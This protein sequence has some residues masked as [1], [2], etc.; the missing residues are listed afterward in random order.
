MNKRKC[1][2]RNE[3]ISNYICV[4]KLIEEI[5]SFVSFNGNF[6]IIGIDGPTAS[7]K[8]TLADS[9]CQE[10][11]KR[12][13]DYF[14]YRLDWTLIERSTRLS[15]LES[16]LSENKKFLHESDLHMDLG[17]AKEF[18]DIIENERH[19][20]SFS[21]LKVQCNNLYN[22]DDEGKCSGSVS[23]TLKKNMVI[24]VEG[25]YTHHRLLR[26][27]FDLNILLI[28]S[29]KELLRRKILRV[30]KYRS[31]EN[32]KKYFNLIDIPS[33]EHYYFQNRS[34]FQ[35]IILNENFES[36]EP[37]SIQEL[38]TLFFDKSDFSYNINEL[39]LVRDNLPEKYA[40][41]R[42]SEFLFGVAG[43]MHNLL[44]Q[45][46]GMHPSSRPKGISEQVEEFML[47][48]DIE[49]RFSIFSLTGSNDFFYEFGLVFHETM[50]IITGRLKTIML[51]VVSRFSKYAFKNE[52]DANGFYS[53]HGFTRISTEE[54]QQITSHIIAPN[55]FLVP[56][57][58]EAGNTPERIFY[59]TRDQ[60][61]DNAGII[62]EKPSLVV[63]KPQ[64]AKQTE[65]YSQFLSLI[66]YDVVFVFNYIFANNL[67]GKVLSEKFREFI[68]HFPEPIIGAGK[69]VNFTYESQLPDDWFYLTKERNIKALNELY[70]N[71]SDCVKNNITQ[72]LVHS[73]PDV[74]LFSDISIERYVRNLPVPL[75]EF[76]FS[77]SVSGAGGIPF[78]SLYH[79][80][81]D[82]LDIQSYFKYFSINRKPFG[83]Q[84][85][86]NALGTEGS[87]EPGYLNIKGPKSLAS[88][89][90]CNLINFLKQNGNLPIWG[91]GID[92]AVQDKHLNTKGLMFISEALKSN[93]VTSFCLD[94]SSYLHY[95]L[96]I[97]IEKEI[98]EVLSNIFGK[99]INK[100]PD[101][102]F[103]IGNEQI[104]SQLANW[105]AI[106]LYKKLSFWFYETALKSGYPANFLL[107]PF[108]GTLH[109]RLHNN[110]N[111]ELSKQI[112]KECSF[113]GFN[114]NVLHGTSF[115][116]H[117]QIKELVK[118]YC[119]KVN[120]AGK[121]LEEMIHSLPD[122]YK[123]LL[124]NAQNDWKKKFNYIPI[125]VLD[126]SRESITQELN[127]AVS[128]IDETTLLPEMDDHEIEWFRSDHVCLPEDDFSFIIRN[129]YSDSE[130]SSQP[131]K[132]KEHYFLASMIEVPFKEFT[133]GLVERIVNSGITR[134]HID[135]G[136]GKFISRNLDGFEKLEYL[137][138][139]YQQV[140]THVHL[141]V[142]EPFS[143]ESGISFI[144]RI[145]R[146]KKSLIYIHSEALQLMSSWEKASQIITR[147]GSIPGVVLSVNE[148]MDLNMFLMK[149]KEANIRNVLVMG[150]PVGRG[151]QIFKEETIDKIK[152]INEWSFSK[153][154]EIRIEI[155]GGL[156]DVVIA[157]CIDAGALFLSGWSMF[158][159]Y[160]IDN[161]E[162]RIAELLSF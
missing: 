124:G 44:L 82:S 80:D 90:K 120:F 104:F 88:I 146:I 7:G 127:K 160:Q 49:L 12:G 136:D 116:L 123:K 150:V 8:T 19:N 114:G 55:K 15:H 59:K 13:I 115:T 162:K 149:M 142:N 144:S 73:Y 105:E 78:F 111:T 42:S 20:D 27:F 86:M 110:V 101:I 87:N 45:Q 106:A 56:Y 68:K 43:R 84:A 41:A 71:A 64:N 159:K 39:S 36:Q 103:Y 96:N 6:F 70:C 148:K 91:F 24:L 131:K 119:F 79:A 38:E 28:A 16:L 47:Q 129:L 26:R 102:E 34:F 29:P 126:C 154:Y 83:L 30:E 157:E 97:E 140:E 125:E 2:P 10:F 99:F 121:L 69:T 155:D 113:N 138:K 94:F 151:G 46:W 74:I 48:N 109:H 40:E 58:F 33:F 5:L 112:Y 18:L 61:W 14:V 156:S 65:F 67:T 143:E 4:M 21:E 108:L 145:S 122:E 54:K 62:I 3:D 11:E 147:T 75:N 128:V 9:L 133:N 25:H 107:G 100:N 130:T 158:L 81:N 51:I 141:M 137:E 85:S 72:N 57:Y 53:R 89:I 22:R 161:I 77:L 92:H 153:N 35:K 63:C 134:F 32:A 152:R 139:H 1:F 50:I 23:F 98:K 76:Y 37:C 95:E 60:L 66:G 93:W 52:C 117:K 31:K 17:K 132:K 118:N 135:I